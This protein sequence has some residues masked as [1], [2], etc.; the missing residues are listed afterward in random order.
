MSLN[1][2]N[3]IYGKLFYETP[4]YAVFRTCFIITFRLHSLVLKSLK[5]SI[6]WLQGTRDALIALN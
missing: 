4:I 2:D 3:H 5:S 6:H 1:H